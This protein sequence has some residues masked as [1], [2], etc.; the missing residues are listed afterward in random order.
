MLSF[1]HL[2]ELSHTHCVAICAVLVPFNLSTTLLTLVLV[3]MQ[4]PKLQVWRSTGLAIGGAIVMMMHVLTWLMVGVVMLPTF[5]LLIMGTCCLSTN[6]WALLHPQSLRY[7]LERTVHH[8]RQVATM[9]QRVEA[10]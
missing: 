3:G 7:F 1:N 2:I 10:S 9:V 8:A 4:R 6:L 5:V